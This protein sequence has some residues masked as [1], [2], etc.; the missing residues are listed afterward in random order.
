[1]YRIR[2]KQRLSDAIV[3]MIVEA[4]HVARSAKSHTGSDI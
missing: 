4:P 2:E 3:L 1:M